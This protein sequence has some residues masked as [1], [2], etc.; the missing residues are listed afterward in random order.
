MTCH[1]PALPIYSAVLC[2]TSSGLDPGPQVLMPRSQD[3]QALVA[4]FELHA[5][6][7]DPVGTAVGKGRMCSKAQ[8]GQWTPGEEE[9]NLWSVVLFHVVPPAINPVQARASEECT[10]TN[11][12]KERK[13]E[14]T[15]LITKNRKWNV[16][17]LHLQ[18][19]LHQ[20]L[21]HIGLV[22]A[23][24]P[25]STVRLAVLEVAFHPPK[26]QVTDAK[27]S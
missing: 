4:V 21:H 7:I 12:N 2:A 11:P 17:F 13:R 16:C 18:P 14:T 20:T 22:L 8:A 25:H 3:H 5:N 27:P 15:C 1:S 6:P 9:F 23:P 24:Q 19:C 10:P 26:L